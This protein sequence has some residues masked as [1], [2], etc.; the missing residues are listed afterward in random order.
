MCVNN[1]NANLVKSNM[2][3]Q[4]WNTTLLQFIALHNNFFLTDIVGYDRAKFC[5]TY[6]HK[7]EILGTPV[8]DLSAILQAIFPAYAYQDDVKQFTLRLCGKL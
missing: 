7:N 3:L 6:T 4:T 5:R 2:C 8:Q 1:V